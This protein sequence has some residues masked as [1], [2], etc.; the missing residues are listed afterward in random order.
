MLLTT[1]FG[2]MPCIGCA[3]KY[4]GTDQWCNG[5]IPQLANKTLHVA[6]MEADMKTAIPDEDFAGYI[7]HDW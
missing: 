1:Y 2:Q 5:G 7:V 4:A 3:G 6:A